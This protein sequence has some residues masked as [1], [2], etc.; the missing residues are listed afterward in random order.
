M[1]NTQRELNLIHELERADL[2]LKEVLD[3]ISNLNETL[4]P[5]ELTLKVN[6]FSSSG[7]FQPGAINGFVC[8]LT[9]LIKGDPLSMSLEALHGKGLELPSII[10][11][12][13]RNESSNTCNS[14][15]KIIESGQKEEPPRF[16]V[17]MRWVTFPKPLPKKNLL[18]IGTRYSSLSES[19]IK[20]LISKLERY[21]LEI[22]K[23]QGEYGGGKLTYH[24]LQSFNEKKSVSVFEITLSKELAENDQLLSQI[25]QALSIL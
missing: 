14:I 24:L 4:R 9:A 10:K 1:K 15:L 3:R 17:N 20:K 21:G 12:A 19:E 23:D 25:M 13:D 2:V 11:G 18:V 5:I 6:D 8:A 7:V 16:I 22:L